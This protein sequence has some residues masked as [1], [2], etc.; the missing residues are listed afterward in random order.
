MG[1]IKEIIFYFFVWISYLANV[2]LFGRFLFSRQPEIAAMKHKFWPVVVC[3]LAMTYVFTGALVGAL[4]LWLGPTRFRAVEEIDKAMEGVTPRWI[5]ER[6]NAQIEDQRLWDNP[7]IKENWIALT[8]DEQVSLLRSR[9]PALQNSVRE[10]M[11]SFDIWD[12]SMGMDAIAV[13]R[14]VSKA[15]CAATDQNSAAGLT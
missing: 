3:I 11:T 14:D 8:P 12:G 10:R 7:W 15:P 1:D 6:I 4:Y 9:G 2:W 5:A 13:L